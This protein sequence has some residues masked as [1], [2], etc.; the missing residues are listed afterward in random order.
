MPKRT[1]LFRN[2]QKTP[3]TGKTNTKGKLDFPE[4]MDSLIKGFEGDLNYTISKKQ[5]N[6]LPWLI[7]NSV[8]VIIARY[9]LEW[10]FIQKV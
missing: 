7:L 3:G 2:Y 5:T 1:I 6:C 8:G 4:Q 9:S 10:F